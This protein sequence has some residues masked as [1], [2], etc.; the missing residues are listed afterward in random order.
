[1]RLLIDDGVV[2]DVAYVPGEATGSMLE[3]LRDPEYFAQIRVDLRDRHLGL[4][5]RPG[6]RPRSTAG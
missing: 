1:M 6:P 2:R 5:Q 3:P 4:A